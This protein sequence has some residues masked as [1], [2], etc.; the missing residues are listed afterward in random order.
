M[1]S[2]R[3]QQI[4][5]ALKW[6][7]TPEL[8]DILRQDDH[9]E[10]DDEAFEAIR[11]L[12]EERHEEV[13]EEESSSEEPID[14]DVENAEP[15]RAI[16]D[17]GG[18]LRAWGIAFI[19]LG[20]IHF[21]LSGFLDPVWGIVLVVL[22]V[23]NLSIRARGMFIVNGLALLAV[24]LMNILS[25]GLGGWTMFGVLQLYWGVKEFVKFGKYSSAED[26]QLAVAG[27][28]NRAEPRCPSCGKPM[29]KGELFCRHCGESL[30]QAGGGHDE[31][32]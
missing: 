14:V 27:S 29:P 17:L 11:L 21:L 31:L 7:E 15:V 19:I 8:I 12:L 2:P 26:S 13:P 16:P 23:L 32:R 24:G 4:K 20:V 10:Y 25:G 28:Q 22:G 30:E 18:E 3:V 1:T 5:E 6:R 9:D